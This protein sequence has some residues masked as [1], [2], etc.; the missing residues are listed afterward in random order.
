MERTERSREMV[1]KKKARFA[2]L[3][4]TAVAAKRRRVV[5]PVA[6]AVDVA[7]VE[8]SSSSSESEV[9]PSEFSLSSS[10]Y[11]S[12]DYDRADIE[13]PNEY[14]VCR[15]CDIYD[16][17][18]QVNAASACT[19]TEGCDGKL[20]PSRVR[21][22]GL[23]GD[24]QVAFA[25]NGGDSR[26]I[27]TEA[28]LASS[29]S[30]RYLTS[31]ALQVCSIIGGLGFAGYTGIFSQCMVMET[32]GQKPFVDVVKVLYPH[33]VELLDEQ[34]CMALDEMCKL[35]DEVLG[36]L[37]NAV[38]TSDGCW[39]TRGSFSK[40]GMVTIRNFCNNSLLARKREEHQ[41]LLMNL[42]ARAHPKAWRGIFISAVNI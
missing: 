33:V 21:T 28:A 27:C 14:V 30:R 42:C 40:N 32:V 2:A 19:V 6:C 26:R 22:V 34:I 7:G 5:E 9:S 15:T 16:L 20:V 24:C 39:L 1:K 12:S 23:G 31:L 13:S 25:C 4:D 18:E 29:S 36:S 11:S 38:T 8:N 37:K 10:E 41:R 17:I 35:P 3:A